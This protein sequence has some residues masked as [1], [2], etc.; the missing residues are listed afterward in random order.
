MQEMKL[1]DC[2]VW[3]KAMCAVATVQHEF[4]RLVVFLNKCLYSCYSRSDVWTQCYLQYIFCDWR[5]FLA[6]AVSLIICIKI[7]ALLK[8]PLFLLQCL[9]YLQRDDAVG[10]LG[11]IVQIQW[12][13]HVYI[14]AENNE[15]NQNGYLSVKL[16][17]DFDDLCRWVKDAD[18]IYIV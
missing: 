9:L 1:A 11:Y 4:M 14:M 18:C 7:H 12:N 16:L 6:N 8:A 2:T 3:L 5:T 17:S 15:R 13:L 10:S